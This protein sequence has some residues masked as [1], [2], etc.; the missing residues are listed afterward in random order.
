MLRKKPRFLN[1]SI[2]RQ[3]IALKKVEIPQWAMGHVFRVSSKRAQS[4]RHVR[5]KRKLRIRGNNKLPEE[6]SVERSARYDESTTSTEVARHERDWAWARRGGREEEARYRGSCRRRW[7]RRRGS[8]APGAARG[9]AAP[10]AGCGAATTAA[11]CL[12]LRSAELAV[13][14][15]GQ[16]MPSSLLSGVGT[17]EE[18]GIVGIQFGGNLFLFLLL[19]SRVGWIW[20]SRET[21][22]T[23]GKGNVCRRRMGHDREKRWAKFCETKTRPN[24][25]QKKKNSVTVWIFSFLG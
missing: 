18:G 15:A 16:T 10:A 21:E 23:R 14:A 25:A 8:R 7:R 1:S 17:A 11:P 24:L 20:R 9:R 5:T 12:L 19:V 4:L 6:H 13:G 2:D 22:P 3:N